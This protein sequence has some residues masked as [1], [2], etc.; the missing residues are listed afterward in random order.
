MKTE[1]CKQICI[2]IC[3][4]FRNVVRRQSLSWI[5]FRQRFA[6]MFSP[7]LQFSIS[8][9]YTIQPPPS[10]HTAPDSNQLC[11]HRNHCHGNADNGSLQCRKNPKQMTQGLSVQPAKD[12]V[13]TKTLWGEGTCVCVCVCVCLCVAQRE[14]RGVIKHALCVCMGVFVC[15]CAFVCRR[16]CMCPRVCACVCARW[17]REEAISSWWLKFSLH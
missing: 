15:M 17:S 12:R 10:A 13:T 11:F 4:K 14:N 8:F 9:L 3:S 2:F 5:V 16:V 7:P 1:T 6:V